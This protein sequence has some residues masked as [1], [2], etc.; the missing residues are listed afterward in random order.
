MCFLKG[1][2]CSMYYVLQYNM[3]LRRARKNMKNEMSK[4]TT[5]LETSAIVSASGSLLEL[6][7]EKIAPR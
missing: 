5:F 4:N 1:R 3:H 7:V 2:K 6:K